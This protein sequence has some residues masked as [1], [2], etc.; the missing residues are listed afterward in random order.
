MRQ[1]RPSD[2]DARRLCRGRE[3]GVST[4]VWGIVKEIDF[5]ETSTSIPARFCT[6]SIPGAPL[7]TRR[8]RGVETRGGG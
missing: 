7:P 5:M 4:D 2:V 1:R 3:V 8:N 6:A